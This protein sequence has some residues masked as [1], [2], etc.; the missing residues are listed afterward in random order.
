TGLTALEIPDGVTS[1]SNYTF[2][3]CT[4]L[5]EII[6]P[7]SVT[8]VSIYAFSGCDAL[9]DVFYTGTEDDWDDITIGSGNENLTAADIQYEYTVEE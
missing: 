5:T 3:N 8:S 6:I 2:S 9:T 7:D 1:I 4:S